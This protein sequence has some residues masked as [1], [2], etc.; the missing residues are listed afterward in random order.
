MA[1]LILT[2][3]IR[4]FDTAVNYFHKFRLSHKDNEYQYYDAAAAA[5]LT[6]CKIEDT[7]K[8]SKEILCAAHNLKVLPADYLTPDDS[9]RF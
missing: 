6:A 4:T 9:V 5:L 8:K 7:L 3:P 1:I 2:S